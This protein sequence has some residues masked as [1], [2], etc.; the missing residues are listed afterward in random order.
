MKEDIE[1][2]EFP[3]DY[4]MSVLKNASSKHITY[5]TGDS[6]EPLKNLKDVIL[7]CDKNCSFNLPDVTCIPVENP[8]LL[9]YTLSER[10]K[11]DYLDRSNLYMHPNYHSYIHKDAQ[12]HESAIIHPGCVIGKCTIRENVI[13]HSNVV[14]YAESIIGANS[15]IESNS[16]IGAEGVMWVWND[17]E[18]VKL[19]QL[20]NV[21]IEDHVFIGANVTIVRGSANETTKIGAGTLIAHGTQIGHGC[22]IG[23]NCHFGNNVAFAGSVITSDNCFFGSGSV[24]GSHTK[25]HSPIILGANSY[26]SRETH[27]SGVYLGSPAKKV[28]EI[29]ETHHGV[30]SN[31]MN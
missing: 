29:G 24:A 30:P 27:E 21:E 8:Q 25:I 26:L 13:I 16:V 3:Y 31:K 9:F 12:I 2:Y 20:G 23:K 1:K 5:Y 4:T 17:S 22:Q 14:I 10:Y 6:V 19:H 15:I 28:S 7:I 18:K 11:K